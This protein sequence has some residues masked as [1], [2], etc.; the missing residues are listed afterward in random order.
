MAKVLATYPHGENG[1]NATVILDPEITEEEYQR[2]VK[3]FEAALNAVYQ[4]NYGISI[5]LIEKYRKFDTIPSNVK[6]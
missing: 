5:K 4:E 3:G 2:N 6:K 1:K